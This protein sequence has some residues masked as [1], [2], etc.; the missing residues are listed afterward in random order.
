MKLN[1][2]KRL[3]LFVHWLIS[4]ILLVF[5]AFPGLKEELR[6]C[7]SALIGANYVQIAFIA[8]AVV[9]IL[10]CIAVVVLIFRRD[11]KRAERG[12]I[13]VDSAETGRVRIA[14]GA[15]EQ[16]V[17]Q[18]V[19]AVDGISDMRISISS[20][21]DAIAINV[22]VA[23]LN[24]S[25]VPT[26]TLNMQRAIRQFVEMNCGVSVRSVSIN[27]QSVVNPA[28]LTGKK[29]RRLEAKVPAMPQSAPEWKPQEAAT[30]PSGFA[31]QPEAYAEPVVDA[32]P[33]P[34]EETVSDVQPEEAVQEYGISEAPFDHV[35]SPDVY[36]APVAQP[37]EP[38]SLPAEEAVSGEWTEEDRIEKN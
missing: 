20:V 26:V 4:V 12:F 2:G 17:K 31:A 7:L 10:L 33:A 15:I 1:F 36:D 28:E 30:Q 18:A 9:Y 21:D 14:V 3:M 22:N 34:V 6:S 29:A 37:E 11:G 27:I 16:M 24:G 38:E 23:L 32:E 8:F 13:T 5:I 35:D 25:H 19:G